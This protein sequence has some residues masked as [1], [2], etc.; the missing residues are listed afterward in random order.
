MEIKIHDS[1]NPKN[2]KKKSIYIPGTNGVE[3]LIKLSNDNPHQLTIDL[4]GFA[5]NTELNRID[6]QELIV[7][8]QSGLRVLT[9]KTP[10]RVIYGTRHK[11]SRVTIDTQN[12][13]FDYPYLQSPIYSSVKVAERN[14]IAKIDLKYPTNNKIGFDR[15]IAEI[16]Q[17]ATQEKRAETGMIFTQMREKALKKS[18]TIITEQA[19]FEFESKFTIS[20]GNEED[21]DIHELIKN[22]HSTFNQGLLPGYHISQFFPYYEV[23]TGDSARRT[24]YGW[25]DEDKHHA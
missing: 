20:T 14:D 4:E 15:L 13:F 18:K 19:D 8:L 17:F 12:G 24:I 1:Q 16:A 9:T 2:T 21:L 23:R 3:K 10:V 11:S 7:Q 25:M 22:I 6:V 5:K